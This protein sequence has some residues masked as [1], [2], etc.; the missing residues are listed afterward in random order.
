[1]GDTKLGPEHLKLALKLLQARRKR[2]AEVQAAYDADCLEWRKQGYRPHYCIHGRNM[3]VD[4]DIACGECE[5]G[6]GYWEYAR[7]AHYALSAVRYAVHEVRRRSKG[8]GE[9]WNEYGDMDF[10]MAEVSTW[11][12]AP[13][14]ALEAEIA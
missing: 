12:M 14:K 7:E 3:W 10:P 1:M 11:A 8:L 2:W 6:E 9:F 4:Y 5:N 13:L